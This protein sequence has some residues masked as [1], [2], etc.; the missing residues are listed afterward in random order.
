MIERKFIKPVDPIQD[1]GIVS[2]YAIEDAEW[3]WH[4]DFTPIQEVFLTFVNEF[5]LD[6]EVTTVIHVSADERYE[7]Y[8][9]GELISRGPDR[10][11]LEHWS[12]ASY[13]VTLSAGRHVLRADAWWIGAH[14][15]AAQ[16]SSHPGFILAAENLENALNTG[17][18]KWCVAQRKGIS[19]GEVLENAFHAIGDSFIIDGKEFFGEQE[20]KGAVSVC[21]Q[22][23]NQYGAF[24]NPRN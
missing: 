15:P 9:D 10:S 23:S 7:L 21:S 24:Y 16:V 8:L 11:G 19:F 13:E 12:F 18:G 14:A 17:F 1:N 20:F 3:I 2:Q 4:P 5:E 6:E 22:T